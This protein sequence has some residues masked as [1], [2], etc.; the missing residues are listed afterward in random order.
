MANPTTNFGWVMPTATDLVTDLPADFAV[1]GQ[2]VD[3]SMAYLLGGTT[4][5]I[6]SKT[7]ATNMA[8][9]WINNDQGDITGVTAGTGIS[10]GGTS[11]TVTVTNSMATAIDAKGDLIAGTGAD[12]FSRLAVGANTYLL[13]ADSAEAT[14]LKWA[15]PAASAS[16]LTLINATT[17]TAQT[18]VS[19]NNC[20]S[21][22]YENYRIVLNY[23]GTASN[24][25][26]FRMRN[27][28]T[29]DSTSNYRYA[30]NYLSATG[31]TGNLDS[32]NPDSFGLLGDLVGTG[33]QYAGSSCDIY[34]PFSSTRITS[35][36]GVGIYS[37]AG[38]N[39]FA[40]HNV[41]SSFDG[42][43]IYGSGVAT[44]T[45]NIR[46]YGYQNS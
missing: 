30:M 23:I 44:I 16:G 20:F 37:T 40:T 43:T 45:G 22:T 38:M 10:G 34:S 17:F 33:S 24:W 21:A 2:G 18:S 4:G 1:F 32:A 26:R 5:Q 19:I 13:T 7:S 28:G 31:T 6:L 3:T 35:L 36:A 15:A 39:F 29:D 12:A 46:I 14:G 42:L 27:S 41:A 9:T 8:F 11:G 25:L